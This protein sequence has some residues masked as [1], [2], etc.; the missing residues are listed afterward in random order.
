MATINRL[1]IFFLLLKSFVSSEALFAEEIRHSLNPRDA[2]Y[3]GWALSSP[4]CPADTTLCKSGDNAP[5]CCPNEY[6]CQYDADTLQHFCCTAGT[7][8]QTTIQNIPICANTSWD[9]Y[10][11]TVESGYF[12]CLAGQVGV[13]NSNGLGF[14]SC[15]AATNAYPS[16]QLASSVAEPTGQAT[17]SISDPPSAT[18]SSST[19]TTSSSPLNTVSSYAKLGKDAIIGIA[20]GGAVLLSIM[21]II[22][23]M[24]LRYR[25]R[26]TG[27]PAYNVS[28]M[29]LVGEKGNQWSTIS[30]PT[31]RSELE[32]RPQRAEFGQGR[33]VN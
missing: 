3:G 8:C 22:A 15:G 5:S 32:Y 18:Q 6:E 12:C 1:A 25:R 7:N 2:T 10:G 16:S 29:P 4:S 33:Y 27:N 13:Q 28:L 11:P 21:G 17:A 23:R 20:V 14:G 30:P 31:S 24:C 26:Q 19:T 9:M